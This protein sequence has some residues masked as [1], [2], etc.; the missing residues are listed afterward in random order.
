[1]QKKERERERSRNK[2]KS[3]ARRNFPAIWMQ[4]V[5]LPK[6]SKIPSGRETTP[7]LFNYDKDNSISEQ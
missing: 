7:V 1:M 6:L 2:E 5:E 3:A 4:A